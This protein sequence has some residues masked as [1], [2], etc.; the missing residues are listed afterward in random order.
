MSSLKGYSYFSP[1]QQSQILNS[2]SHMKMRQIDP[3]LC[4]L[5]IPG[6]G[7][8]QNSYHTYYVLNILEWSMFDPKHYN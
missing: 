4:F 1:N 8:V 7:Q 5:I 2:P 3:K 6:T